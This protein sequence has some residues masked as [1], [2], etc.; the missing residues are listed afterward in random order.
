MRKL[1]GKKRGFTLVELM[2][3]VAIVGVLAA[4]AIYGVRKYV[5]NAKTA[6]ARN[7]LGQIGKDAT[8]AFAR[9][10]MA[11]SVLGLGSAAAKSN[12]LCK[13]SKS[14]PSAITSVKGQKYQSSPADWNSS[15]DSG[16]SCLRFSMQ[17]PQYYQYTYTQTGATDTGAFDITA[18][19]NLDGD[20][21]T[22]KFTYSG[23]VKTDTNSKDVVVV[24]A[25][26]IKE[27]SPDE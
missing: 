22:S 16:W 27:S 24:M 8:T 10:S 26:N 25:P 2:I 13:T 17:D 9:E 7:T 20:S 3:V 4:L 19:G 12:N 11:G 5:L 6:E 1:I 21:T 18:Q 23:D 15:A 14:V